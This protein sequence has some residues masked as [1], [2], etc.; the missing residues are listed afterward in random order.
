[1]SK[2]VIAFGG[3]R[4][5]LSDIKNYGTSQKVT[6]IE[7]VYTENCW[8]TG[9][10]FGHY[11]HSYKPNYVVEIDKERYEECKSGKASYILVDNGY[12]VQKSFAGTKYVNPGKGV[13]CDKMKYL[14]VTTYSNKN[15]TFY[16]DRVNFNIYQKCK[17]IDAAFNAD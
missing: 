4:I 11:E 9:K 7:V 10:V 3:Q 2:R 6:Y 5:F 12:G 13:I 14:Y 1:M 8:K 15:Y 16:A 17:E